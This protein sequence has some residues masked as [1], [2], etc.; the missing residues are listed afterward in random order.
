MTST[1]ILHAGIALVIA[2]FCIFLFAGCASLQELFGI[3]SSRSDSSS[4]GNAATERTPIARTPIARGVPSTN[5]LQPSRPQKP[6][7]SRKYTFPQNYDDAYKW[8]T[9]K[10]DV[11]MQ[12]LKSNKNI[13]ALRNTNVSQYISRVVREINENA[14]DDFEKAKMAHD[15]TALVLKYD[16]ANFWK[17][18]VPNQE[19]DSVLRSGT[20]VCE[21]YA[22]VYK[23]FCDELKLPCDK[24]HGYARGV[25]TTLL[26]EGD[27][28][29]S[30]HAWNVV[31]INGA[32]Y[33]VD[34]TWDSGFMQGRAAKQEYTT[35]WLFIKAEHFIYSH[36]PSLPNQQL[37]A[38]PISAAQFST[39]PD[40]RPKFFDVA[41]LNTQL[42]KINNTAG[43]FEVKYDLLS[44]SR[45]TFNIQ[46]IS[47]NANL[48]NCD[49]IV[50]TEKSANATF[51]F[52]KAGKY[53]VQIFFWKAG[54]KQGVSCGEFIVNASSESEVRYPT[55]YAN[56][57][58]DATIIAPVE[59]PLKRGSSQKFS[60]VS[61]KKIVC[62]VM[63]NSRVTL[64]NDGEGNFSGTVQ[65]PQNV[66]EISVGISDNEKS[67]SIVAKYTVN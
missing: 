3:N 4:G 20:A 17:G 25:G 39:L 36:L 9:D 66:K 33:L 8:R 34:C 19:Y 1:K 38:Q 59:M 28:T 6:S 5:N 53:N 64:D 21:G 55:V 31:Q 63:G 7:A 56:Y 67:Y 15:I 45:L 27:V 43:Q 60:I 30:N 22:N 26:A 58:T 16:A 18:T 42:Q 2:V 35:D 52:P 50:A 41:N 61:N 57:G 46:N 54:S 62:I 12:Q 51:S 13:D 24:I 65:I 10:A 47:A 37:L 23:K 32:W 48:S 29:D 40:L 44:E 11:K 49:F 14:R